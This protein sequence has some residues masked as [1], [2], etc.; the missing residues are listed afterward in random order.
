MRRLITH[1]RLKTQD[2]RLKKE[3]GRE[4]REEEREIPFSLLPRSLAPLRLSSSIAFAI[5]LL[6]SWAVAPTIGGDMARRAP[7]VSLKFEDNSTNM[8]SLADNPAILLPLHATA[9][10]YQIDFQWD[11][12]QEQM[13]LS[14][15]GVKVKVVLGNRHALVNESKL[16]PLSKPPIILRGAVA[17]PPEDIAFLLQDL[18]PSMDV[19]WDEA[20]PAIEVKK[21]PSHIPPVVDPSAGKF[22]LETIVIDPGHGG[23][24]PGAVRRGVQEKQIVLDVALRLAKLIKSGSDWECILTRDSDRFITL[25][26]RTEI[27]NQN[28]ADSTLFISIHCNADRRSSV[29]GLET[30]VFD[31]KA[32]DAEA[33]ALAERENADEK[34]D[35]TYIL[36]HCYH[37]GTEPYSLEAAKRL[38]TSLVKGLKLRDRGVKRAPFYVLAGTK[39][40][41]VLVELGFLSNHY[42]RTELK[43]KEFRQSAAEA[44]FDAI[45][46]FSKAAGKL[47][48]RAD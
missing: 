39:M 22:E 37:V 1:F 48:V 18:L 46:D 12:M 20:E 7:A 26:H 17:V 19:S 44:L 40:P 29:R 2:S 5:I 36:S 14:K 3:K 27:A 4:K 47:I 13:V 30:F 24:D 10:Y 16:R 15:D 8:E 21:R 34:M 31:L 32:T 41:A 6:T 11:P 25:R 43:S 38:Q 33:A 23:Y 45:E 42:D 9:L 28:S 35:L